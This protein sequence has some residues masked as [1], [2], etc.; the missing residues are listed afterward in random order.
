MLRIVMST[1]P[2]FLFIGKILTVIVRKTIFFS[3][4]S[5]LHKFKQ[6][7]VFPLDPTT[8]T[9]YFFCKFNN[10]SRVSNFFK[11]ISPPFFIYHLISDILIIFISFYKLT[12]SFFSYKFIIFYNYFSSYNSHY[13]ISL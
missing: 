5:S 4:F 7:V 13:W 10:F 8:V 3:F 6:K 1:K 12:I 9:I 11:N 2:Y